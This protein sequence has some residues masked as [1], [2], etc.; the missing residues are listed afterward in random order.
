MKVFVILCN[1]FLEDDIV[2]TD[3]VAIFDNKE[4]LI[5]NSTKF[6]DS[7][8]VFFELKEM[9]LNK[10]AGFPI[11]PILNQVNWSNA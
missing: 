7:E 8:N 6:V 5:K 4:D 3:V 10:V 11:G 9:E 2:F 1:E